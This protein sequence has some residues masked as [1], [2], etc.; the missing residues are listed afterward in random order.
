[1]TTAAAIDSNEKYARWNQKLN[2][3]WSSDDY[4]KI[5]VTL[6]I[7]GEE[8]TEAANFTPGSRILDVAAGNGNASLA[9][10]RRFYSVTSTDCVEA[11][12]DKGR[13][14]AEVEG[15]EID[16][17]IADAQLLPFADGSFD[18]VVSTFGVMF[19]PDQRS[20]ASELVRWHCH[21]NWS[22]M[23]VSCANDIR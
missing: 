5:G 6:Q 21:T 1:M 7:T 18:G 2:A 20:V 22:D 10:V 14:R 23:Q 12:L 11:M 19:A 13:Q 9:F 17:Q 3:S 15:L 8:L 4:A 16:F